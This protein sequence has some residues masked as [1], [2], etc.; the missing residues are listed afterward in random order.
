MKKEKKPNFYY[1]YIITNLTLNN[2]QYV[3]S[4]FCY[5]LTPEEDIYWGSSKH[6]KADIKIYGIENFTKEIINTSYKNKNDMLDGETFYILKFN[7]LEPNGYNRYLPNQK[8]GFYG[9]GYSKYDIWIEKYGI[10]I[11][12][13]KIKECNLKISKSLKGRP[14]PKKG[15]KGKKHTEEHIKKVADANRGKKRPIEA[16]IKTANAHRGKKHSEK[17]N[18]R[19][20]ECMKGR[21]LRLGTHHTE[22]T[23]IILRKRKHTE[24]EKIKMKEKS[25]KLKIC[26][27]CKKEVKQ[28]PYNRWHGNNCKLF[29]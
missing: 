21:K 15:K 3:G 14:S 26:P 29:N 23:K 27:Y 16:I 13:Q 20:S 25:N 9:G 5:A 6:V 10:E 24:E 4:R 7:T 12:N 1:V 19:H 18:K 17:Q 28:G 22:E 2:K 11:A 8:N